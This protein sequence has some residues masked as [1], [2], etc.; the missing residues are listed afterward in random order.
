MHV[1]R[2]HCLCG[3]VAYVARSE[4]VNPHYCHCDA[5][6]RSAGAPV[7]AWV[8]FATLCTIEEDGYAC[9]AIGSLDYPEAV[10]PQY[11]IYVQHTLPWLKR[12]DGL[13]REEREDRF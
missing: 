8:N 3:A 1:Y 7:V 13:R 11:H 5:C 2:G 12:D 9:V 4:P 6:R 10:A